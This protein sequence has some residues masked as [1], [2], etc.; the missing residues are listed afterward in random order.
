MFLPVYLSHIIAS[1]VYKADRLTRFTMVKEFAD[2]NERSY[3][4]AVA[5][6]SLGQLVDYNILGKHINMYFDV[7][8]THDYDAILIFRIKNKVKIGICEAKL[9][10]FQDR[11]SRIHKLLRSRWDNYQAGTTNSHF[12]TQYLKFN[13]FPNTI[14]RWYMFAADLDLRTRTPTIDALGSTCVWHDN[15]HNYIAAQTISINHRWKL[16]DVVNIPNA[17]TTNLYHIVYDILRCK[18][19]KELKVVKNNP[20]VSIKL[21]D[22]SREINIPIP[23]SN[24]DSNI[25]IKGLI[26][27]FLKKNDLSHYYYYDLTKLV[28]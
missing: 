25:D 7:R 26:Q 22:K 5:G 10:R 12:Y 27:E 11:G 20:F 9:L 3:M 28:E 13:N 6:Y 4:G 16:Q 1:T 14:A 19:G 24:T 17:Y 18:S 23:N 21:E 8:D 2:F 15:M